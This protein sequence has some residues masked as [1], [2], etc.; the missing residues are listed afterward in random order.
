LTG[1]TAEDAENIEERRRELVLAIFF[2][3]AHE[4]LPYVLHSH[5]TARSTHDGNEACHPQAMTED[6][7]VPPCRD[8]RAV[9]QDVQRVSENEEVLPSKY[10]SINRRCIIGKHR[11]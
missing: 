2:I 7:D 11:N 5:N 4:L 1:H 6:V 8:D 9:R 3:G 10:D